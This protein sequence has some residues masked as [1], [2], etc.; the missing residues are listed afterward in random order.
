MSGPWRRGVETKA[1]EQ[2][3]QKTRYLGHPWTLLLGAGWVGLVAV[4][5]LQ[6]Y[7]GILETSYG[8][9]TKLKTGGFMGVLARWMGM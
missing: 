4:V 6:R 1:P 2:N 7:L 3:G 9:L 5:F 8:L